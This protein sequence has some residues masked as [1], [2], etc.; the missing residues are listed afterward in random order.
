MKP[1]VKY[2]KNPIVIFLFAL[3]A[4]LTKLPEIGL[5]KTIAYSLLSTCLLYLIVIGLIKLS[6]E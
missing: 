6:G 4:M 2:I 5:A 3:L 1:A